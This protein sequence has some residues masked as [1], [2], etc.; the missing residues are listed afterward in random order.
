[1]RRVLLAGLTLAVVAGE[2]QA[3]GGRCRGLFRPRTVGC[4]GQSFGQANVGG[5]GSANLGTYHPGSAPGLQG[6]AP[7]SATYPPVVTAS[8][9]AVAAPVAFPASAGCGCGR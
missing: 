9:P 7:P 5:C 4:G 3:F 2:S 1:M 8:Y 6:Y